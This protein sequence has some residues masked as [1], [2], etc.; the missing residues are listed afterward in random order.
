MD[1]YGQFCPVARA[2]EVF[3]ERW[4]PL[5]VRELMS[6]RHHFNEILKGLHGASPTLLG[7]RLRRLETAGIV[8]HPSQR[9]RPR[10]YVLPDDIGDAAC[11]GGPSSWS[12]GPTVAR[13]EARAL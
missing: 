4:T 12:L 13:A 6:D 2:S 10:F 5:I 3:A 1:G 11:C 8:E 9:G 7:E